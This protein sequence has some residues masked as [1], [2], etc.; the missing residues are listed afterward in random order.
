MTTATRPASADAGPAPSLGAAGALRATGRLA[1]SEARLLTRNLPDLLVPIAMPVGLM[2]ILGMTGTADGPIPG[3]GGMSA[4]ELFLIPSAVTMIAAMIGLLNMP[5]TMVAYRQTGV[6]RRLSVTPVGPGRMLGVQ[7]AVN[8]VQALFGTALALTVFALVFD[9]RMP[10]APL[11]TA[12]AILL[13]IAAMYGIGLVIA[14]FAR[15]YGEA[16][17]AGMVLFFATMGIGGGVTPTD[18]LPDWLGAIGE[19][20]P[21]GAMVSLVEGSWTDGSIAAAPVAVLAIAALAGPAVARLF[22]RWE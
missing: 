20:L 16:L 22:F 9:V 13:G 12:G 1:A 7:L 3:E 19:H 10:A 17:G 5:V 2:L 4:M 11:L 21:F 15:T 8:A 18:N 14:S 6:L